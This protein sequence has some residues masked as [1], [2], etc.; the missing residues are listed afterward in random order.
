[1]ISEIIHELIYD[2]DFPSDYTSDLSKV[3]WFARKHNISLAELAEGLAKYQETY[4]DDSSWNRWISKALLDATIK[5]IHMQNKLVGKL[6]NLMDTKLYGT[7]NQ[8]Y[9]AVV[10]KDKEGHFVVHFVQKRTDD[11]KGTMTGIPN[12]QYWDGT[13]GQYYAS[14]L[15]GLDH[16]WDRR[17]GS[18]I[19]IDG[20]TNWF[21][22]GTDKLADEIEEKY[23]G[24]IR[25]DVER[26]NKEFDELMKK[27]ER[28]RL[29]IKESYKAKKV[30][31]TL[32]GD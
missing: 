17:M 14:T 13:P 30:F 18:S 5:A 19:C 3:T 25:K 15:L 8:E 1:M 10:K 22:Y 9:G 26:K 7:G 21:I 20:G 6:P 27:R 4:K 16:A 24:E 12:A 28:E 29:G 23:G 11:D 32:R 2:A 31:E